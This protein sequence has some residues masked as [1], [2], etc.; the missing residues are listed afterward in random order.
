MY[1]F[2]LIVTYENAWPNIFY[3]TQLTFHLGELHL[4]GTEKEGKLFLWNENKSSD[5]YRGLQAR[6]GYKQYPYSTEDSKLNKFLFDES[7]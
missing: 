7:L 4:T 3:L 2:I 6:R 1:V 5:M